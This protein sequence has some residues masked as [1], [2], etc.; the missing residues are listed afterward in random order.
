MDWDS[1]LL[2]AL[3]QVRTRKV[4]AHR[5]TQT[6]GVWQPCL[7]T[8]V[9]MLYLPTNEECDNHTISSKNAEHVAALVHCAFFESYCTLVAF[10]IPLATD[11]GYILFCLLFRQG[12]L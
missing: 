2:V 7:E 9:Q 12:R 6:Q 5:L 4:R 10:L 1:I 11:C 3:L 8:S